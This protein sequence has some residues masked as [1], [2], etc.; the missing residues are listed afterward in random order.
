MMTAVMKS[1]G[2]NDVP[3]ANH[4]ATLFRKNRRKTRKPRNDV[5]ES[6]QKDDQENKMESADAEVNAK[7]CL[8]KVSSSIKS[9]RSR[10][11]KRLFTHLGL[12]G[13]LVSPNDILFFSLGLSTA[14][15]ASG[16]S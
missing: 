16:I 1:A 2:D 13:K 5:V 4:G 3:D 12:K 10:R 15:T 14:Q 11:E 6:A 7:L 9:A 8:S